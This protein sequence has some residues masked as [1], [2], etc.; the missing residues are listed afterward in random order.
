MLK[1][2]FDVYCVSFADISYNLYYIKAFT[3]QDKG[4]RGCQLAFAKL[5]LNATCLSR[6]QIDLS[7]S[8]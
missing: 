2:G 6:L 7:S 1:V 5:Q 4:K 3:K 8:T